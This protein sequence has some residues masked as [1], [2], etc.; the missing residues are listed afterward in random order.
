M[1]YRGSISIA[2]AIIKPHSCCIP[3][4]WID[5]KRYPLFMARDV[6]RTL[7]EQLEP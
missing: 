7:I 1:R 5:S 2:F 3:D 4:D 6:M